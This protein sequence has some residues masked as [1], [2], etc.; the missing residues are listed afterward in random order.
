MT[1]DHH[2]THSISIDPR[3]LSAGSVLISFDVEDQF[4]AG[5]ATRRA[6]I[7]IKPHDNDN[8]TAAVV[9][10]V[11]YVLFGLALSTAQALKMA[12]SLRDLN[13]T[14]F[15]VAVSQQR[16]GQATALT[17]EI[18]VEDA[19]TEEDRDV[20]VDYADRC[21]VSAFLGTPHAITTVVSK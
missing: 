7:E 14:K 16:E 5:L 6:A 12:I 19:I 11:E 13:I 8:E 20:L 21:P 3:E 2:H 1:D 15:F 9:S 18:I 4:N 10:P 17:R